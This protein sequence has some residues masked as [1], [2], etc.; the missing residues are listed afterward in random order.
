MLRSHTGIIQ[1]SRN[2]ISVTHLAVMVLQQIGF[3]AVQH[4]DLPAVDACGMLG[5][6]Q[7]VTGCF[8][9]EQG[10]FLFVAKCIKSS[11]RV[12]AATDTGD[13]RIGISPLHFADLLFYLQS[14]DRLKISYHHRIGV[15]PG[16]GADDV[17]SIAHT[18]HPVAHGF[19]HC[20]FKRGRAAFNR[21]DFRAQNFHAKNIGSL[22]ADV[23]F[24]HEYFAFHAEK[25]RDGGCRHAMLSCAG[26]GNDFLFAHSA[27]QK[28]LSQRIVDFMRTGMIQI[29]ALEINFCAAQGFG[30]SLGIIKWCRAAGIFTP[31][32]V[33]LPGKGLIFPEDFISL[34]QFQK[35][36]HE[37]FGC[38]A[39]PE[40]I[41][42]S[43]F[44]R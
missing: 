26:F 39:A 29:L 12:G 4:A 10:H 25:R 35:R 24:A 22:A 8:Y 37:G 42:M 5:R 36:G 2:G 17:K 7:A 14:D 40:N 33:K 9:T 6:V 1:T 41:K 23:F 31:V 27:G 43:V 15:R 3:V 32:P 44:V 18:A 20:V 30:Q 19:I 28:R 16:G 21:H 11:H 38:I 34:F 13:Q